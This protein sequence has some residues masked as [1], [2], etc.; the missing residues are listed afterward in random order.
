LAKMKNENIDTLP[1]P[2]WAPSQS[3]PT[4]ML[5]PDS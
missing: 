3:Q 4:I 2:F 5:P 1:A